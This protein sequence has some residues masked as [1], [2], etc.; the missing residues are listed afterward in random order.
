MSQNISNAVMASRIEPHDSLDDFP[1]PSWATR[2]L[3]EYVLWPNIESID[4]RQTLRAWEPCCNRGFMARPLKEYFARVHTSDIFDYSEQSFGGFCQ[5]RVVDFL[6]PGSES[7]CI[8]EKGVDAVIF[9][10]PF[11]LAEQFIKRA[12]QIKGVEIVAALVRT[13]FAEG[14]GRYERLFNKNA[15]SFIAHFA[16]RVPMVKGRCDPEASTATAYAW[17]VWMMGEGPPTRALWIPPCRK[18]LERPGDYD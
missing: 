9:N 3:V 18:R 16:E 12:W 17:F 11:R 15:P 4:M 1:T 8:A 10:P 14:V 6:F 2:A 5:D 13:N 7:P